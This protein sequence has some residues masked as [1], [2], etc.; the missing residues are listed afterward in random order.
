MSPEVIVGSI[1][2]VA[3][4]IGWLVKRQIDSHERDDIEREVRAKIFAK[5]EA[6]RVEALISEHIKRLDSRLLRAEVD[7]NALGQKV[8]IHHDEMLKDYVHEDRLRERMESALKP[9]ADSLGRIERVIEQDMREIYD[10][11]TKKMDR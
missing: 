6:D 9:I 11:L 3:G 2:I 4:L 7:T 1:M 8:N 10:R 5:A